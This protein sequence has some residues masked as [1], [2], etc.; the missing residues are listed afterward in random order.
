MFTAGYADQHTEGR[1]PLC[2]QGTAVDDPEQ[3]MTRKPDDSQ[4]LAGLAFKIMA[5]QFQV[6]PLPSFL[7]SFLSLFPCPH[8]SPLLPCPPAPLMPFLPHVFP[9][10][11]PFSCPSYMPAPSNLSCGL[12]LAPMSPHNKCVC[13]ARLPA[14]L[15]SCLALLQPYG[16]SH[17]NALRMHYATPNV[18]PVCSLYCKRYA[19]S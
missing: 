16:L 4:P 18:V 1:G 13:A 6:C 15:P 9:A 12:L 10:S 14:F 8:P 19:T 11:F 7:P 2:V 3:Q 5:D 17:C